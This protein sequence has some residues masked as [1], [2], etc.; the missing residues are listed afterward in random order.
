MQKF[1]TLDFLES[2]KELIEAW[3]ISHN[4][5]HENCGIMK[6]QYSLTIQE[7]AEIKANTEVI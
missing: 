4:D 3:F 5:N 6:E 1:K 2:Q 7:L